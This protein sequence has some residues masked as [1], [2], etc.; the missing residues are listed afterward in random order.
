MI[1]SLQYRE[2]DEKYRTRPSLADVGKY[3]C[4]C[5]NHAETVLIAPAG[6]WS[7][8]CGPAGRLRRKYSTPSLDCLQ[9]YCRTAARVML[10][11]RTVSLHMM[12]HSSSGGGRSRAGVV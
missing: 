6:R 5:N 11:G 10:I 2:T 1:H 8:F 7:S 12:S 3:K 9:T 4:K